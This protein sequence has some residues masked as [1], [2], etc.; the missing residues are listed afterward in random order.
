[1]DHEKVSRKVGSSKK[2]EDISAKIESLKNSLDGSHFLNTTNF[3]P[4]DAAS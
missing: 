4:S 3:Q 2:A 1:M